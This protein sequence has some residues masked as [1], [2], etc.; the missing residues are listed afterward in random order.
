[1]AKVLMDTSN[2]RKAKNAPDNR[3]HSYRFTIKL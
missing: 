3:E 2:H 1:M